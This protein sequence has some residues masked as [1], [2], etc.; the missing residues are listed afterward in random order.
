MS[1]TF[2]DLATC[3]STA[4]SMTDYWDSFNTQDRFSIS[5]AILTIGLQVFYIMLVV[6]FAFVKAG[7]MA[8]KSSEERDE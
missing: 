1:G 7:Q 6:Y 4:M 5:M 3:A 8:L 2:I